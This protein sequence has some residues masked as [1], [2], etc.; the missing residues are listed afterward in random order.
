MGHIRL[1]VLPRTRNWQQVIDLLLENASADT[2]ADSVLRAADRGLEIAKWDAGLHHAVYLLTQVVLAARDQN[3]T[4]ALSTAGVTVG[5]E[6]GIYDLIG[7]FSEAM[8]THLRREGSRT[9]IGEM[10]QLAAVETLSALVG[11]QSRGLFGE[12]TKGAVFGFSTKEGF[13][14]LSH[15]FFARFTQ[16]FLTYHLDRELPNHIGVNKRFQNLSEH[17]QF[18]DAMRTHCYQAAEIVHTFSGGWYSK[19]NFESGITPQKAKNFAS[20]AVEKMRGEL[21]VRG[22]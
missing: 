15:D 20:Y 3:F 11:P 22:N 1:G 2:I 6:P 17:S 9:D 10:A 5:S 19:A 12:D 18:L 8:D 4:A 7:G 14:K 16:R 13:A 21:K